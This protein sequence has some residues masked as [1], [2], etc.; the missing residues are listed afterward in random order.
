M[1]SPVGLRGV[2]GLWTLVLCTA[3]GA[4]SFHPTLKIGD[5]APPLQAMSW[6][7][8]QPIAKFDPGRVYVVEFWATWCVPCKQA[9]PHLSILQKKH[10]DHLTVV[11]VDSREAERGEAS[12]EAVRKFVEKQGDRM[13]YTVAMDDPQKETIFKAWMSAAGAYGIPTSFVVDGRGRVVWVGHPIG[14]T[15]DAFDSAVERALKGES[16]LAAALELQKELNRE[17]AARL[18]S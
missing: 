15:G 16:D 13:A 7:K 18:G 2:A 3:A 4:D 12:P 9:M 11:G 6:I 8:G 14:P 17:T 5:P 10:A 1:K